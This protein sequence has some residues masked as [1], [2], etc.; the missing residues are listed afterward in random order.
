MEGF[1]PWKYFG[2]TIVDRDR[3]ALATLL[4]TL[5]LLGWPLHR[6]RAQEGD[7]HATLQGWAERVWLKALDRDGNPG[8]R[9]SDAGMLQRFRPEIDAEY[10]LDVMSSSFRL[11]EESEWYR[12]ANG[13]RFRAASINYLY[14]ITS[15]DFKTRVALGE[16]WDA[17]IEFHK[18]ESPEANRS[19]LEL[20]ARHTWN[21]GAFAYGGGTLS[22]RKSSDDVWIGA[23]A[24]DGRRAIG[25]E[26]VLLDAFSDFIYQGL[27]VYQGF[28]D[29]ALDYETFPV[30][31]RMHL[32]L[33]L[34][35]RVRVESYGALMPRTRVRAYRQAAP[36][37]GFRQDETL[38]V[39]AGLVEWAAAG[40]IRLGAFGTLVQ[41]RTARTPLPLGRTLDAFTLTERTTELAAF[42]MSQFGPRWRLEAWLGRTFRPE[43]RVYGD[44]TGLDVDYEDC[45]WSGQAVVRYGRATGFRTETALE[46][47]ARTVLRGAGEVL[48]LEPLARSNARL[49]LAVGWRFANA[50]FQLGFGVDLDGDTYTNHG[51][52]DGGQGRLVLYW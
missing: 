35:S 8:G 42:A 21:G 11:D 48:E 15:A 4:L 47:D 51:S 5:V 49:R 23:G 13:V 38:D 3:D 43:R 22:A 40:N 28:A 14:L 52:F 41:A 7:L 16:R 20:R 19:L 1:A 45:A 30:A 2:M 18:E 26:V 44:T 25:A 39:L 27:K 6:A 46:L 10:Q 36:D 17:G 31:F 50:G 29:T 32:N 34:G 12:H 9:L 33:P 37:S 24:A